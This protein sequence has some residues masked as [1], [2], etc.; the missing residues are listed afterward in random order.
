M[1]RKVFL[2]ACFFVLFAVSQAHSEEILSL[3]QQISTIGIYDWESV[4]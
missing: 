4:S 2:V 3:E 1:K